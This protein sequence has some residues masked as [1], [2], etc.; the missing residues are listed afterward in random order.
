MKHGAA[1]GLLAA[2]AACA[3]PPRESC[4][5]VTSAALTVADRKLVGQ[6]SRY[7]ADGMLRGRD[8]E[9][10]HSQR[11]R[12]AAAWAAVARVVEPVP[13]AVAPGLA[14]ASLPRW[15]TW[16][17][18]DDVKRIFTHGFRA[19]SPDEQ[20]ARAP[21]GDQRLDEAFAWNPS[22]VEELPTWPPSRFEDYRASIDTPEE[23]S[24]V[25]GI[26][27]VQYSPGATRH[28]LSSYA[29]IM[30][31]L[32]QPAPPA[33][34]DAPTPGPRRMLRE[35]VEL[36]PCATAYYGP[37]YVGDGETLTASVE[38]AAVRSRAAAPPTED[39]FDCEAATCVASGPGP[40]YLAV[41]APR[42]TTATLTIDYQEADPAWAACLASAFPL[43][44]AIVKADWRRAE[45]GITVPIFDTSGPALT[46]LRANPE[47]SWVPIG[48]ADPGP[49]EIYSAQLPNGARYRLSALHLMTKEL[50]HWLWVT[51]WWSASPNDDFGADRPTALTGVWGHYKMCA[52][53]A[54]DERDPDPSGGATD[55]SL[56]AALTAVND[57]PSW[58][59]NPFIENGL[60]NSSSSCV[61]CHQHGGTLVTPE[62][63][64]ADFPETGRTQVRNNFPTDYSYAV[65]TGDELGPML[66]DEVEYWTPP[67]P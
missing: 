6:A 57:A 52:V 17:G 53:V 16:Y 41:T 36:A 62:A 50:D 61:G 55:P 60:H 42:A 21:L 31:C 10:V 20:R 33:I 48:E 56:A 25:A 45:L 43:D 11:A 26:D 38:G 32:G 65:M 13:F 34:A 7:P 44:A 8:D 40:I 23:V 18:K 29:T 39:D 58:C 12:R 54:F 64:L 35:T 24:G 30:S 1:L 19:L 63:V 51:I 59:S 27:R 5:G 37:Y 46:A 47:P 4:D 22:A 67:A 28:L 66:R 9:L 3:D 2:L 49:A 14:D 15:H